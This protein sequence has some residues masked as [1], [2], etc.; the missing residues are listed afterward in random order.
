MT[1]PLYAL[2]AAELGTAYRSKELSPVEVVRAVNE[3]IAAL[4]PKLHATWLFRPE[5]RN[6]FV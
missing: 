6:N 5:F 2:S 4:E 3:R 1:K